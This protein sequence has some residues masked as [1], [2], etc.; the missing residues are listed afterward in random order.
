MRAILQRILWYKNRLAS[1]SISELK[2]RAGEQLKRS[3]SARIAPKFID[4]GN[5]SHK[6]PKLLGLSDG[7][8]T[9]ENDEWLL[10]QWREVAERAQSGRIKLLGIEWPGK[11]KKNK[12]A[13]DPVTGNYWPDSVYCFNI[14]YRHVS[15]LG[16]V[17]YVWE[18]N[19]LQYLQPVAAF[20][21]VTNDK[22]L[23]HFCASEI[24]NWIDNNPP[25]KGV[26]WASGI[27]LACRIVT[28]LTVTSILGDAAFSAKQQEK[29]RISL[30]AHGYWLMRYPSR[31]SSA[32]NHLIAE[33]GALFLL[34]ALAPWL[35]DSE[36][37]ARYGRDTL[38]SEISRQIHLDGVGAEQSPTY[39]A[40]SLE[41]LLLCGKTAEQLGQPF[42]KSYWERITLAGEFLRWITDDLGN[43]PLIGDDDAGRVF[44]SQITAETYVSSILG[45]LSTTTSRP[46]LA[47][48]MTQGHLREAYFGKPTHNKIGPIGVRCFEAGGYTVARMQ[49]AQ[50]TEIL[51]IMDHG[52]LG[53][54][55]IA[56]HGHA[57][58]LAVWLHID[59]QPILVDA[60][61]YLYHSGGEWRDH[62][63]GTPAHNTL[64]VEGQDSSTISGPFNWSSKANISGVVFNDNVD[65][66]SIE[67]EHD[68]YM[69]QFGLK[70]H[71]RVEYKSNGVFSII[72]SLTGSCQT[73]SVEIGFL[74]HP[75]LVVN[76]DNRTWTIF[77]GNR[78]ILELHH[79]EENLIG[80]L[81]HGSTTS[82]RGWHSPE[83]GHKR[84]THRIA[85][86]GRQPVNEVSTVTIRSI[87]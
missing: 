44:Y 6:L 50:Q 46:D 81:Q 55:S 82:I 7:L 1:M 32:N 24:E 21:S 77:K 64:S 8:P 41:W 37:W 43:Q 53:Y 68:G 76:G 5:V 36:R 58:A 49:S 4:A 79:E 9:L 27:E 59:G 52:A 60:G 54:L 78:P 42:P 62:M 86:Q 61:T 83:F 17:K 65:S 22:E 34:G 63:R 35:T 73:R 10:Q 12:W 72:D 29:L 14:P 71:R 33:A 20:A 67:A 28:I 57:D 56:A 47:P 15:H 80:T 69:R 66:W 84:P 11:T 31:F 74:I 40:F 13:L 26:N 48:P 25:F 18:F 38:L 30:A 16:D 85:F 51:F 2:H 23:A 39:T 19:R 45:S 3:V 75:D 87:G 70:H